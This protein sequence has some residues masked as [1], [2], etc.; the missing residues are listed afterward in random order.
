[1]GPCIL[2]RKEKPL[3]DILNTRSLNVHSCVE[4]MAR[5]AHL[6]D[7]DDA[8]ANNPGIVGIIQRQKGK[9]RAEWRTQLGILHLLAPRYQLLSRGY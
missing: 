2:P 1:M 9:D 3:G 8:F 4:N 5:P 7:H 6:S